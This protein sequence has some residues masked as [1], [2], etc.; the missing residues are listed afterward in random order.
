MHKIAIIGPECT[1]KTTLSMQLAQHYKCSWVPEFARS[2]VENLERHYTFD[3]VEAIARQQKEQIMLNNIPNQRFIF[4][5]T[6]LIITK[7]WF[8]VVFQ[9]IPKWIEDA[10]NESNFDLYLLCSTDIQWEPDSVRENGGSMRDN[11]FQMYKDELIFH[12]F[13]FEEITGQGEER[14]N[15]AIEILDNH[16]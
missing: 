10:I 11:L 12:N 2:Y 8:K 3:D 13:K 5:D 14:L 1:G 7:V 15:L 9:R 16:F 6:D 4:F